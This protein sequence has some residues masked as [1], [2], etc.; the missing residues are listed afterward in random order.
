MAVV[1]IQGQI[2]S[3][4]EE[5]GPELASR[6]KADYVDRIILAEAG[7][8]LGATVAALA[9]KEQNLPR[10]GAR[11][12]HFFRR[13]LE[14]S[15][16]TGMGADP[17]F[18]TG[19]ETLSTRPYPEAPAGPITQP[20]ALDDQQFYEVIREVI[21]EL[22]QD[23]NVVILGR[24]ANLILQDHPT[25]LHV[26]VVA[27]TAFRL[28]RFM[29]REG[30]EQEKAERRLADEEKARLAY[31]D[32]HFKAHPDDPML[33]HMVVNTSLLPPSKA[34]EAVI[35]ATESLA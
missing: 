11:L 8:R 4:G 32:R 23:G 3:G 30:L 34:V 33:Y 20:L 21:L 19:M 31:F 27:P 16:Y 2:A 9:E 15:A 13:A 12:A 5:L 25:A 14:H 7:K 26:G 1:T 22:A 6:L 29:L 28:Q 35:R 17:L 18:G 10:L 24:G